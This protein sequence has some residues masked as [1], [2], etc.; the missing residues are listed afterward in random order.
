MSKF[1]KKMT[2]VLLIF[3]GTFYILCDIILKMI[4]SATEI[5]KNTSVIP[6]YA[7]HI[8]FGLMS[9]ALLLLVTVK[10]TRFFRVKGLSSFP[11]DEFVFYRNFMLIFS[12]IPIL[13]AVYRYR[14]AV[15]VYNEAL[16]EAIHKTYIQQ[17]TEDYYKQLCDE[18]TAVHDKCLLSEKIASVIQCVL[19]AVILFLTTPSLVK[20][21][22]IPAK[23][24][25][26][27][28]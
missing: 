12:V 20:V 5:E 8:I 1:S 6:I 23:R 27:L 16:K 17:Y 13:Y 7:V 14:Y 24:R 11:V 15:P 22:Q 28:K 4:L 9:S 25:S 18:L 19:Q 2:F 10:F 26:E 21:Y 3:I